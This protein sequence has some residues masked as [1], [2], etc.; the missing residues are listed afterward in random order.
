MPASAFAYTSEARSEAVF[1][2]GRRVL[3]PIPCDRVWL[4]AGHRRIRRGKDRRPVHPARDHTRVSRC[5]SRCRVHA[6]WTGPHARPPV[7]VLPRAARS[8]ARA[9][10]ASHGLRAS[11]AVR[12]KWLGHRRGQRSEAVWQARFKAMRIHTGKNP[13]SKGVDFPQSRGKSPM[14]DKS[15]L[16]SN[17][18]VSRFYFVTRV[19]QMRQAGFVSKRASARR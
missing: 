15:L 4:V 3:H 6:G 7:A 12:R 9:T 17:P 13:R 19:E 10:P 14:K 2:P 5:V 11:P 16:G 18:Q 8:G 1:G